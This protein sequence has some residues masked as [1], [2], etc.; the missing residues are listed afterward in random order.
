MLDRLKQ[1]ITQCYASSPDES[2]PRI[3]ISSEDCTDIEP[4][5][6]GETLIV[7][8]PLSSATSAPFHSRRTYYTAPE[9]NDFSQRIDDLIRDLQAWLI[10][11]KYIEDGDFWSYDVRNKIAQIRSSTG[12]AGVLRPGNGLLSVSSELLPSKGHKESLR[13]SFGGAN[14]L[15]AERMVPHGSAEK[16]LDGFV[17]VHSSLT[18]IV[19]MF[20]GLSNSVRQRRRSSMMFL[21]VHSLIENEKAPQTFVDHIAQHIVREM[22]GTSNVHSQ[23]LVFGKV[24][25]GNESGY[26]SECVETLALKRCTPPFELILSSTATL[27]VDD[28]S[29]FHKKLDLPPIALQF[30]MHVS[31]FEDSSLNQME[32]LFA[33]T[34]PIWSGF[35]STSREINGEQVI[36]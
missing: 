26:I 33:F 2:S 34:S 18:T 23:C 35:W 19:E 21:Y 29:N 28:V 13:F 9:T 17:A 25:I 32:P 31:E 14:I 4:P 7:L 27:E 11:E 5:K 12:D 20:S 6:P 1:S 24:L 16:G 22:I 8:L 3:Q 30:E 36:M 10:S 15:F